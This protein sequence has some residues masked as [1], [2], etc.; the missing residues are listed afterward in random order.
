MRFHVISV[1]NFVFGRTRRQKLESVIFFPLAV[2]FLYRIISKSLIF[3][4]PDTWT[5]KYLKNVQTALD[6][7][8]FMNAQKASQNSMS[9]TEV[10]N[11]PLSWQKTSWCFKLRRPD[12]KF[13][14]VRWQEISDAPFD[15]FLF[16]ATLDRRKLSDDP[17]LAAVQI[18]GVTKQEELNRDGLSVFCQVWNDKKLVLVTKAE[19]RE[20]WIKAWDPRYRFYIPILISCP[21]SRDSII[22]HVSLSSNPCSNC[23]N[24][25]KIRTQSTQK[26]SKNS[27]AVCVKGLS[28]L[29]DVSYRLTE[30]IETNRALGVE[31]IML[32]Y[33]SVHENVSKVLFHYASK[34]ENF[35]EVTP[36][37]LPGKVPNKTPYQSQFINRNR[38]Q[39]RRNELIPYNDCLYKSIDRFDWLLVI[40]TDE[41]V[42]PREQRNY[43]QMLDSI[44]TDFS[45]W[46][47]IS[48]RNAY[49][50]DSLT[51]EISDKTRFPNYFHMLNHPMRSEII[52][53]NGNFGKSFIRVE[54]AV[55]VFNHFPLHKRL[56][57]L[58]KTVYLPPEVALK[59]HYKNGCPVEEER[60][61]EIMTKSER[62][63]SLTKF[64]SEITKNVERVLTNLDLIP[65]N[66]LS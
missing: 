31:K 2:Y 30:W 25:L 33:Y 18:L 15:V 46:T 39:K 6:A 65:D 22:S 37:T 7:F 10:Y 57:T 59:N 11:R 19:I 38:Q 63:D 45:D 51:T 12:A 20:I 40:D 66:D 29:N 58:R 3:R 56:S 62:D 32:Y 4:D 14:N 49:Y 61:K 50:F 23:Q 41:I 47:A 44:S 27:V 13:S 26:R 48:A 64:S 54:N 42:V 1:I 52:S 8:R 43:R 35:L 53:P 16:S 60:C 55:T 36:L 21:I 28:F 5:E 17:N 9:L 24:L 34:A